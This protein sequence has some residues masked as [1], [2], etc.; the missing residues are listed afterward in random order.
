MKKNL[1]GLFVLLISQVV[2]AQ[3][4]IDEYGIIDSDSE[5]ARIDNF[6]NEL[7]DA[8]ESRGL[9]VIYAGFNKER[10][11][12]I[13]AHIEGVK[14]YFSYRNF[15]DKRV[16]FLVAEGKEP[17]TKELWI[18]K[19]DEKNPTFKEIDLNLKRITQKYLYAKTCLDCEPV[20]DVL[21][22]DSV[23]IEMLV[24]FLKTNKHYAILIVLSK[25]SY[26][27]DYADYWRKKIVTLNRIE[28]NRVKIKFGKAAVGAA[29]TTFYIIPKSTKIKKQ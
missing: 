20:V 10:L 3:R 27:F 24:N 2:F 11:G 14:T 9:V 5:S 21:R 17:L 18:I 4:I 29:T 12:N 15:D 26:D 8:P 1:V 16:S 28:N 19:K 23:K 13:A 22:T 25:G 6:L 7:N